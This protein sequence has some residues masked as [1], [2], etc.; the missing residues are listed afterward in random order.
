[1]SA[2]LNSSVSSPFSSST[3]QPS[4]AIASPPA[5]DNSAIPDVSSGVSRRDTARKEIATK[6]GSSPTAQSQES[7][8]N[9]QV[10]DYDLAIVG[11]GIVGLT[12]A[13][14]LKES[15]MT[16]ALI[17]S[18]PR[19]V[20]FQKR[21]AYA[22][23]LMSG[24]IW[25]GLGIWHTILPRITT[26]KTI[27]LADAD[28]TA[29]V[30]LRPG[31]LGTP[32]LGY[33]AEHRVLAEALYDSLE[34]ASSLTCYCP[35]KLTDVAHTSDWVELTLE[36]ADQQRKLRTKLLVAADGARSPIRQQAHI[37][38]TGWPYWQ[39]CVTAVIQPENSH[40][41]IAREH[42]WPSGPFATLPLTENRCQI[43]LTAPHDEAQEFL[44]MPVE[45]F[46]AELDRR[47]DHQ[48]GN[49]E[50][51]GDRLMFPVKLMQSQH[52]VRSRLALVGDAA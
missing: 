7:A 23:T 40:G 48:L 11:G 39:S 43:V 18:Q 28:C 42:F 15:G 33:V 13:A 52:Y 31:D 32:E 50:I 6:D 49:L 16:V 8:D 12:L 26:F 24:R 29:V 17:E 21:R 36:D 47:Y 46:L 25:D 44:E 41:A 27:R 34:D 5:A 22:V 4:G 37:K 3:R 35:V 38:T 9:H 14:A 51:V 1:M 19:A 45:D 2:S 10:L 20:A 30:N